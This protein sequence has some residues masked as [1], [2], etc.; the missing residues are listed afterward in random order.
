MLIFRRLPKDRQPKSPLLHYLLHLCFLRFLFCFNKVYKIHRSILCF[1]I[2]QK[3]LI[4]IRQLMDFHESIIHRNLAKEEILGEAVD[5]T[6]YF[7]LSQIIQDNRRVKI[8][9]CLIVTFK[10]FSIC[11]YDGS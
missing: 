3:L 8:I 6:Q 7:F 1:N 2:I 5:A 11:Y 9:N 10:L 4:N